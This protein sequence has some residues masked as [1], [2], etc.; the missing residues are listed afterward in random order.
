MGPPW[1]QGMNSLSNSESPRS[2]T[3]EFLSPLERTLALR[4][5]FQPLADYWLYVKLTPMGTAVSS[6]SFRCYRN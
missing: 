1:R 6:I 5:G 3:N 4:Q 2:R